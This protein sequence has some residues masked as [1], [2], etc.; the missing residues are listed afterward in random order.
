MAVMLPGLAHARPWRPAHVVVVIEENHGYEQIIGNPDAAFINKLAAD[1]ALLT[2]SH[3]I[4]HPS[5]PN[6]FA[7]YAGSTFGVADSNNHSLPDPTL[8]TVLQAAGESFIGY[9]DP[10]S[11]RR[12]NPWE[13]FPEGFAV[14]RNISAFPSGFS[15]LPDMAFVIPNLIHDMHDGTVAQAAVVGMLQT[16]MMIAGIVL[17]RLFLGVQ[18]TRNAM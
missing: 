7:L 2:N 9:V 3:G 12:H 11:P 6:Y 18:T 8:A 4:Q 5:Q 10:G 15:Q 16:I 13:S 1:G 14:E 17:A